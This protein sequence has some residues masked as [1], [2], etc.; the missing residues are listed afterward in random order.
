MT[1][2]IIQRIAIA[3]ILAV[4]AG[5]ASA[6][7]IVREYVASSG[8]GEGIADEDCGT[9]GGIIT[10]EDLGGN[11]LS[12]TFDNTT[13]S[14]GG[15]FIN[16]AVITGL[17][18]DILDDMTEV[19]VASFTDK[20]G[21]DISSD[22]ELELNVDNN[23]TPG[24]TVVDVSFTTNG[25]GGSIYNFDD[26]GTDPE[27]GGAVPDVAVLVLDIIKPEE[28]ILQANGVSGDILRMQRVGENGEGS[29]KIP[30][31]PGPPIIPPPIPGVPEPS[32]LLLMGAGLLGF[33]GARRKIS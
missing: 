30:G 6:T 32:V 22:W 10:F 14:N 4:A 5:S 24:S 13:I 8:C 2:S 31:V 12:I 1:I 28:W 20:D 23:I 19:S 9:S 26:S 18:F 3:L 7:T 21:I 17:V 29:L 11:Q 15:S 16:Q 25:I 27:V 33:F